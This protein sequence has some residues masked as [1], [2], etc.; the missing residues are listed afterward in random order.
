VFYR[1][2]EKEVVYDTTT[3]DD[4]HK[5]VERRRNNGAIP[6]IGK[7]NE[8]Q[9]YTFPLTQNQVI[10]VFGSPDKIVECFAE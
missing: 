6:T 5:T 1:D 9:T 10:H 4:G 8:A 3:H 7:S 2:Y